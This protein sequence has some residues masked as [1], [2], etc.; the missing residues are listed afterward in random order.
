MDDSPLTPAKLQR[1]KQLFDDAV[2]L[3]AR[4]REAY[5]DALA[6]DD[7]ALAATLRGLLAAHDST[8]EH[9]ISPLPISL[10]AP[11]AREGRW[12]GARVGVY[13]VGERIGEG[14][15]GTVYA[16][17]RKDDQFEKR[18]ALKFLRRT[19]ESDLAISR[20][21]HERQILANLSHP[22]IAALVDGGVAPDGQPY[23]AMEYVDGTP[24][25]AWCEARRLDLRGRL[26]LFLQVCAAVQH[27]HQHLVIHRD[28]KPGN[29]L[30]T[31]DGTV[32]LLDFGIAKLLREDEG[33]DQLPATQGGA[34][35]FTPDYAA[36]EQIRGTPISTSTDVYALG[37]VLFEL[38]TGRRPFLLQGRLLAEI[39]QIVCTVPPPRPSQAPAPPPPARA[40]SRAAHQRR[41]ELEG[42]LDAIV[43]TA[44]RKEPQRRYGSV[45]QLARDIGAYLDGLPVSARPD[46]LGY[47]VGKAIRRR[48]VE[49][50]AGVLM[51]MALVGGF[52]AT[53]RQARAAEVQRERATAVT[54]FVTTMLAAPDP[55][56][57][58][59]EVTMREV[60]DSAAA[61][62][63]SLDHRPEL[64]AEVR[65]VI[66]D[67]Y[68]G[69]GE[70][71]LAR[72]QYERVVALRA[73]A[74]PAGDRATVVSLVKL[75][76]AHSYVSAYEVTDSI[77]AQATAVLERAVARD[78]ILR[79]SVLQARA[80]LRQEFGD[81]PGA[82]AMLRDAL[83][84]RLRVAPDDHVNLV[85]NYNDLGVAIGQQGRAIEAESLHVLAVTAARRA[86]GEEHPV[87]ATAIA[88]H[89][90]ALE[91]AD[92]REEADS[93]YQTAIALRRRVIGEEHP[94][95][96]WGL[97][98]YAQFL[99]RGGE[100]R[101]AAARGREV[102]ALRGRS[103]PDAHPAVATALQVV[104]QALSHLD[105]LDVAERYLR[106]SLEL[107]RAT[108]P[109]GHWLVHSG[110]GVLGEH[111]V[112]AR[113]FDEA[114]RLLV[115]SEE[116]LATLRGSDSP[117]ARDARQRLVALYTAWQR[118]TEAAQWQT[119]LDGGSP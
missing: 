119:I 83:T 60:L 105:S 37:V 107:R 76:N 43:L 52:V 71:E 38:L 3:P 49:V 87:T 111:L 61:R 89:A 100:W 25:T 98:Q 62:V 68:V 8:G 92:R 104:G 93:T 58:G 4:E 29:I 116:R 11:D 96:A 56:T 63:D 80:K 40:E 9:L 118:P 114:E 55:G 97:F 109:D 70:F 47:R 19:A 65:E 77:L 22:N 108:L 51:A 23:F 20:F 90:F 42:D 103:L 21:R 39:E 30:V 112:R 78:D 115:R 86:H 79:A 110:E 41:R 69:L 46:A 16:A 95:Y 94:D 35:A 81:L 27:A 59:R 24:I 99:N 5:L 17:M 73:V 6:A 88:Q 33:L 106:E 48:P 44:L 66:G 72:A 85:A 15:M 31:G 67:T 113:R 34:R 7:R 84:V 82:E 32:K 36:P 12:T 13:A 101:R 53:T 64:A 54:E 45:D 2:D 18:V 28:L 57:L 91:M 50:T 74:V 26:V 102:L 10:G 117:Q 75:S 1:L 14:G